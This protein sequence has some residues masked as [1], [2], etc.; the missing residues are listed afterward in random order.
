MTQPVMGR[1]VKRVLTLTVLLMSGFAVGCATGRPKVAALA[2]SFSFVRENE[3]QPDTAVTK[4]ASESMA[5]VDVE[6]VR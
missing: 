3:K 4:V 1:N 2:P 5:V 6:S